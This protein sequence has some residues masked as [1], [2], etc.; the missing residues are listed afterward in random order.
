MHVLE[1]A[2]AKINWTLRV[3]EKGADGFHRIETVMMKLALADEIQM[4]ISEGNQISVTVKE[5]PALD[6][7]GNLAWKAARLYLDEAGVEKSVSIQI[8]KNIFIGGGLAGGSSDG[9]AVL[10]GLEKSLGHLGQERLAKVG[11]K[12][13]SDVPFFLFPCELGVGMGRGEQITSW[14]SLP[15]KPILLVNPGFPVSTP[16]AYQSL[17]RPLTWGDTG[18]K[19]LALAQRPQKWSDLE[20]LLGAGNDFQDVVER[21]HPEIKVIRK[22]LLDLGAKVSQMS[23]SGATVFALFDDVEL[24]RS[25]EQEVQGSWKTVV[26]NTGV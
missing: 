17:H 7:S 19:P 3:F 8:R 26:T 6:G 5:N 21:R 4:T 10:R 13:G 12:L 14:P 1:K 16:T 23:G 24:A 18:D 20:G 9:A 11:S 2:P 25:A 15:R 22:R